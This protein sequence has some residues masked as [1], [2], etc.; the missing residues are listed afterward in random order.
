MKQQNPQINHIIAD[1]LI[2]AFQEEPVLLEQFVKI[3]Q[4]NSHDPKLLE[5][6]LQ[7]YG[8]QLHR[9]I[10]NKK[11]YNTQRLEQNKQITAEMRNYF[12]VVV[13]MGYAGFF[14]LWHISKDLVPMFWSNLAVLLTSLSLLIYCSRDIL[15][16]SWDWLKNIETFEG[17]TKWFFFSFIP[18]LFGYSGL[19]VLTFF[20]L[21]NILN[22]LF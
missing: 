4:G 18:I 16:M 8:V 17:R 5:Q 21:K 10:N 15:F 19:F 1:I 2:Q 14:A 11:E 20:F 22:D 12:N 9:F 6:A 3:Y 13:A 7:A